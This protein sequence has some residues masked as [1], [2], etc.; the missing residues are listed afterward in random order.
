M[1]LTLR[2]GDTKVIPAN[3]W[4]RANWR[5]NVDFELVKMAAAETGGPVTKAQ[6]RQL[7]TLKKL[8]RAAEANER[9][10]KV[11]EAFKEYEL[12]SD[13]MYNLRTGFAWFA[14]LLLY[15]IFFL[16]S[17]VYAGSFGPDVTHGIVTGWLESMLFA[18]C[19]L[20]PFNIIMVAL[21]PILV[22]E[23]GCINKCY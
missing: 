14:N 9:K 17:M 23:E 6:L 22:P 18:F 15:G 1:A 21:I 3:A 11:K 7:R 19:M 12:R 16:Y 4:Q 8:E 20:E 2:R 13:F 5:N 10:E